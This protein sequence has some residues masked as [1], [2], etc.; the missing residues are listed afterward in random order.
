MVLSQIVR[1]KRMTDR[2]KFKKE[3]EASHAAYVKAEKVYGVAIGLVS[4]LLIG[5]GIWGFRAASKMTGMDQSYLRMM[6]I[7]SLGTGTVFAQLDSPLHTTIVGYHDLV[8][9]SDDFDPNIGMMRRERLDLERKAGVPYM[10][11]LMLF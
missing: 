7:V 8:L 10:L 2:S 6:S 3:C 4:L 5:K 1:K 9:R 11:R